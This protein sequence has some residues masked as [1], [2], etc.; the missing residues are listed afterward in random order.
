MRNGGVLTFKMLYDVTEGKLDVLAKALNHN[1]LEHR[2]GQI[3]LTSRGVKIY[4]RLKTSIEA[5]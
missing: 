2:Q 3:V 5:E 4:E 1:L